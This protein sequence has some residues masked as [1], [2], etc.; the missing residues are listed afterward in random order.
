MNGN[1]YPESRLAY[2]T[3]RLIQILM[4]GWTIKGSLPD[5]NKYVIIIA[6]HTSNWDFMVALA[7]KLILRLNTRFFGKHTLFIGPLGWFMRKLGGVPIERSQSLNRVEQAINEINRNEFFVLTITPE[8][9]RSKVK[10]WKTGFYHIA[11]GAGIPVL[12]IAFDFANKQMVIGSPIPT[13]GNIE[14][15]IKEM[16]RFFL[17]FQ[18]KHPDRACQG[19]FEDDSSKST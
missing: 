18:P 16:H 6:H 4:G 5:L 8:G 1:F 15:D 17:P 14:G 13:T 3:G 11:H 19:P 10:S 12:P 9:T 2:M 7:V